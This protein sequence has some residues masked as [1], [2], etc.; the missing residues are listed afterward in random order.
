[1]E[2]AALLL[3]SSHELIVHCQCSK[4]PLPLLLPLQTGM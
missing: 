2:V 4:A 1:M 3:N